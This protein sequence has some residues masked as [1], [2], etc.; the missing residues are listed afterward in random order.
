MRR[1]VAVA[2]A[3]VMVLAA[4]RSPEQEAK[5]ELQEQ[6]AAVREAAESGDA[7]EASR[8][9]A[10]LRTRAAEMRQDDLLTE[11]EAQRILVASLQVQA[12][13]ML[14]TD[15]AP[16]QPPITNPVGG[17]SSTGDGADGADGAPGEDGEDGEDGRAGERGRGAAKQDKGDGKAR[18]NDRDD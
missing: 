11:Q 1:L 8:A 10:A 2:L 3:G 12:G 15:T 7:A 4:C 16:L 9:L 18:G 13:L 14:L 5:E 17:S 6:V